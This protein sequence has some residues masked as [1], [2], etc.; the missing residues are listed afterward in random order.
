MYF[1]GREVAPG[2]WRAT[3][4]DSCYWARLTGFGGTID[5]IIAN[6]NVTGQVIVTLDGSE[7]GFQS[8]GCGQ[9][10]R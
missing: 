7:A 8:S 3:P 9:W 4:S 10:T 2:T 5:N 1:V 6:D